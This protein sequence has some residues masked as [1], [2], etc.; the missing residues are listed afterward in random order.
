MLTEQLVSTDKDPASLRRAILYHARYSIGHAREQLTTADYFTAVAL[1]VRDRLVESMLDTLD[2][3]R[4]AKTK[5]LYYLSMEF[6]IGRSLRQQP[7]QPRPLRRVPRQSLAELGVNIADL[8]EREPD[9]ALGNGGLGRLAACFLDSL[10]TLG[11]PGYGYGINYEYGLFRQEIRNGEQIEKPDNWR[12]L[13]HALADRTAAGRRRRAALRPDRARHRPQGQLQPDVARLAGAS[14]AC[15]TTCRSPAIGGQTVNYLRLFSAR[16]SQDFDMRSSTSATT[17]TPSSRRCCR[18]PSRRCSIP[19]IAVDAGRELRL[20]QEYF[21]VACAVRDIVRRFVREH[22]DF[23]DLPDKVAIQLNDTHPDLAIAELMRLLIDEHDLDWEQAWEITAAVVR[24]H[25]SHPAA[26]GAGE[27]AGAACWSRSC[28]GICRSSTRSIAASWRKWPRVFP[29][30]TQQAAA[31]VAHRG[32]R[33]RSRSAWRILA[34]VGSH[35]V[36]GVAALHSELVK[37]RPGARFLRSCGPRSS[38]TRPTASRQRRWLLIGQ[39]GPGRACSRDTIGDRLDH[40]PR[41]AARPGASYAERRR[42]PASAFRRDQAATTSSA[43][44]S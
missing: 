27:L 25:Q 21:L 28:R 34:I 3:Y 7:A 18:R 20:M 36:N 2:R 33:A 14:S 44:R 10:A 22:D 43:W 26:R 6:L 35:S 40:R 24:L 11:L 39:P 12:T 31:D 5:R 30:D 17:S 41:P 13:R 38:T 16:A 1:A 15:R 42:L 8:E 19:P 9:A 37:T 32:G 29:G 23:D 4:S